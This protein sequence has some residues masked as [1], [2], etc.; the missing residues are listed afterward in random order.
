MKHIFVSVNDCAWIVDL[1][2]E[3]TVNLHGASWHYDFNGYFQK[4]LNSALLPWF[5]S[6]SQIS[7][8]SCPSSV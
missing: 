2:T 4:S 1:K 5:P 7:T 3:E 6:T 8:V